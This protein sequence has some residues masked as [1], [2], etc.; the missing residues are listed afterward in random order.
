MGRRRVAAALVAGALMLSSCADTDDDE[1]ARTDWSPAPTEV[2]GLAVLAESDAAGFRLH[3][4][5][6]D[7]EFLPGVN[8]GSTTPL[9]QPGE[10]GGIQRE[11]FTRWIRDMTGLGVRVVRIYTLLPPSFYEELARHNEANPADPLYLVQG[12][13]LPDETY[14]EPGSTLHD[15][16]VDDAFS[17]ELRDISD[18][19]H[20]DLARPETPGRAS[21]NYE[22]DVSR[23]VLSWIIG[24]EWDP[25]GVARTDEQETEAAYEPGRFFAAT[26]DASPTERWIATHMDEIAAL[27]AA[28]GVSVP[29]AMANWPTVDPLEHPSEP[30]EK[31][32][33]VG[34]DA[35]HVLPTAAWP[36]GTFASF[37][38]Y[39]Y[40]PDFLRH[41]DGLDDEEWRGR[42]DRYAGYLMSLKRH[43]EG[44][45]PLLVTEYGVPSSLGSAHEGTN[46]RDQ[47][48]HTEQDAMAMNA[49]M[50]RMMQAKGIGAAFVFAWTDEWF[51]RTWNTMEHQDGERR[52][53]WHDPLT[54]EQW[55]G[56][57]ATDPDPVVDAAVEME[58]PR[59]AFEY[60]HVWADT[61][62]VHLDLTFRDQVPDRLRIDADVVPGPEQADYRV[63]VNLPADT[64]RVDVRRALDPIRLDTDQRPYHPD[65]AEPWHLYRLITNRSHP[66]SGGAR[67]AEFHDVGLLVEGTW[68]PASDDFDSMST[69]QVD[70]E[71]RTVRLRL[72]WSMLGMADPSARTALGEGVPAELVTIDGIGLDLDADG[73]RGQVDFTWPTWNFTGWTERPKAGIEVLEEA[74]RDLAP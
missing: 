65:E 45:M 34:V 70:E 49:D 68:D 7:K 26:A 23:W 55:F 59:G 63:T 13:Y 52:Q 43:F 57:V 72:P 62:W 71:R 2:G 29:V 8:L 11:H 51:K 37:H 19:V 64:A 24:V 36:G 42:S 54:N 20:G 61:S 46:G 1:T 21:G 40:Y 74:F 56:L 10:V 27:E 9:R 30:L 73:E 47:G 15:A 12:I 18:A 53:L 33:L 66:G 25:E 22:M 39:P 5:S 4:G 16:N 38:A 14:V 48:A 69:W 31:E 35:T 17:A 67:P 44:T 41:E 28:R 32:D 3:T 60:V 58:Q 50:M 6:G